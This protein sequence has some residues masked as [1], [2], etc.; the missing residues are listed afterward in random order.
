M[1]KEFK[2][3]MTVVRFGAEDVIAT[4]SFTMSGFNAG[5]NNVAGDGQIRFQGT[6]YTVGT[7]STDFYNALSAAGYNGGNTTIM[8]DSAKHAISD[9]I[10]NENDS[11]KKFK[12]SWNGFFVWDDGLNAFTRQ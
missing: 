4:S 10:D 1:K 5:S 12:T 3:E 11:Q 7:Q 9:V 6:T 2:P 8:K